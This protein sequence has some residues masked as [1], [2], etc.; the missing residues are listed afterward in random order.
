[1][2]RRTSIMPVTE[3][4]TP[5]PR[6][7]NRPVDS[8]IR[9]CADFNATPRTLIWRALPEVADDHPSRCSQSPHDHPPP[10]RRQQQSDG[11]RDVEG[12]LRAAEGA[13]VIEHEGG[14]EL[15][16]DGDDQRA[17]QSEARRGV[18]DAADDDQT[19]RTGQPAVPRDLCPLR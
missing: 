4:S 14:E 8:G 18:A 6:I 16:G 2:S 13:E 12:P 19:E 17:R 9:G 15:R 1:M 7:R 5:A 3:A 10:P 11:A